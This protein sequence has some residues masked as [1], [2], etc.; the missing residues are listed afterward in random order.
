MRINL[1]MNPYLLGHP[2]LPAARGGQWRRGEAVRGGAD[3]AGRAATF[4][5]PEILRASG[6]HRPGR[7]PP[8]KSGNEQHP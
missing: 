6:G 8:R 3:R 7:G 1:S 2:P 4:H 5:D